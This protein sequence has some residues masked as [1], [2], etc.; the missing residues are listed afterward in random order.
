MAKQRKVSVIPGL[1]VET[2]FGAMDALQPQAAAI[3]LM[4]RAA[5]LA[6]RVAVS[7]GRDIA[8]PAFNG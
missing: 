1:A 8:E 7:T 6:I 2:M 4:T 3:E 5:D